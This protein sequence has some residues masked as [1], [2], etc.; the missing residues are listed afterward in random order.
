M[1]QEKIYQRSLTLR[2]IWF[3]LRKYKQHEIAAQYK[4]SMIM[5]LTPCFDN[6][7]NM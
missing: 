3:K 2:K 5:D 4:K 6:Q 7:S 1:E